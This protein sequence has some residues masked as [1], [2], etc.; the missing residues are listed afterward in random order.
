LVLETT[1]FPGR[2]FQKTCDLSLHQPGGGAAL[3]FTAGANLKAGPGD[4]YMIN[5]IGKTN[6]VNYK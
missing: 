5:Y 3:C 1:G 2:T 6:Y 4:P